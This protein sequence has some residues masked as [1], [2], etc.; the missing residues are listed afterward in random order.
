M[1]SNRA[2]IGRGARVEV[3]GTVLVKARRRMRVESFQG[4]SWKL[5][6][7]SSTPAAQTNTITDKELAHPEC[8]PLASLTR[9]AGAEPS[10]RFR[11]RHT[12]RRRG[13]RR[14]RGRPWKFLVITGSLMP[15][16]L[17]SSPL[18]SLPNPTTVRP[19]R[20]GIISYTSVYTMCVT[21]GSVY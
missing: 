17:P 2:Y 21:L 3:G 8:R 16:T 13:K 20:A 14:G 1:S 12:Y 18:H 7:I 19:R 5:K 10:S 15:H 9:R 4:L 11:L 6:P